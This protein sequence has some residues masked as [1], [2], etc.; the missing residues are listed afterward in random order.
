MGCLLVVSRSVT[1]PFSSLAAV[2]TGATHQW[3]LILDLPAND[4]T[5]MMVKRAPEPG[6]P[7]ASGHMA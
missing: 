6:P 2:E 1:P 5:A 4:A 7:Y 3:P